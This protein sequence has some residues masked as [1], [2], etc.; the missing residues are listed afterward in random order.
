MAFLV[1]TAAHAV[2]S[3]A[4]F[5]KIK[6]LPMLTRERLGGGGSAQEPALWCRLLSYEASSEQ[7]DAPRRGST[8][9]S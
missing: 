8:V 2:R 7:Q 5:L 3:H 1:L 4:P 9:S 6:P